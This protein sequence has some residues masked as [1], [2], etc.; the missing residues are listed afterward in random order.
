MIANRA[1]KFRFA[2]SQSRKLPAGS[3]AR[4]TLNEKIIRSYDYLAKELLGLAKTLA[5]ITLLRVYV[6]AF[7][8]RV[9]QRDALVKPAMIPDAS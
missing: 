5:P 3:S 9:A 6:T 1:E 8:R 2:C 7:C 4:L